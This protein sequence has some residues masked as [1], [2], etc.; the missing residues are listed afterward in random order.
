MRRMTDRSADVGARSAGARRYGPLRSVGG[1]RAE[2]PASPEVRTVLSSPDGLADEVATMAGTP[3]A[4]LADFFADDNGG[5]I[6]RVVF[7]LD[8]ERPY[9]VVE[10]P[11]ISE[12]YDSLSAVQPAAFVEECEIYEQFGVRPRGDTRLGR[13]LLPPGGEATFPQLG[14]RQRARWDEVR[15]SHLV[16][17]EAFELP[18]GPVRAVGAESLYTGLVT[19]GEELLDLYLFYWHKHRGIERAITGRTP[20]RALFLV[21][22]TE[23]LSA[24]TNAWAFCAAVE[25]ALGITVSDPAA[26]TR[27]VA[28]EL[29]RIYNHAGALAALCQATGLSV[30][31]AQAEMVLEDALRCNLATFGHRYLFGVLDIGGV[32]RA[33]DTDALR[34]L[35]P[36]VHDAFGRLASDLFGTNSFMDRLEAAGIVTPERA[37]ALGLVGPLGRAS[38]C[39]V[40]CRRDHPYPPWNSLVPRIATGT[41]GDVRARTGV[42]VEEVHESARLLGELC[43]AAGGGRVQTRY[44]PG[45]GLGWAESP[46]GESLAWVALDD[47]GRIRRARLRPA[48]VRNW[49]AFDDAVR[50]RNVFTDVPII[51]ASFWL[52]VAGAA[53]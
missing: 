52:T 2:A 7:G 38:G 3:G 44:G 42:M 49:R 35:L 27:A 19:T 18:F 26:A 40:D 12:R 4:R 24:V 8:L 9:V 5:I 15:P 23:G 45:Q 28:S 50:S 36:G 29:E 21:E 1:P 48:A 20:E 47:A 25:A 31:Q 17:G 41:D 43:Q 6:L 16:R 33:P 13:V 51:E 14:G 10:A 39:Q 37:A 34:R 22:R 30:G 53:R 32:R 11:V 46:R